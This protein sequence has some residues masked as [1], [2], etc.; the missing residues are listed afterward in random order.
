MPISDRRSLAGPEKGPMSLALGGSG[1]LQ[2]PDIPRSFPSLVP[3]A[4]APFG[5]PH[6]AILKPITI[7]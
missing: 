5:V 1:G 3:R 4:G 7:G 6:G 2:C